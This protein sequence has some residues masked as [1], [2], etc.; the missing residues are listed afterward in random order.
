MVLL[1]EGVESKCVIFGFGFM[2]CFSMFYFV[3]IFVNLCCRLLGFCFMVFFR[4][5]KVFWEF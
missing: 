2:G 4:L 1:E 5:C 3:G